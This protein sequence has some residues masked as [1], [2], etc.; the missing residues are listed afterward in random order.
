MIGEFPII[1]YTLPSSRTTQAFKYG[2]KIEKIWENVKH[3]LAHC[4][5]AL[6]SNP[7]KIELAVYSAVKED[8]HP[9]LAERILLEAKSLFGAAKSYSMGEG[10]PTETG[11]KLSG[12]DLQKAIAYL[13]NGQPWPKFTF[14][15]VE[16]FIVY[17]FKL[18]D[19]KTRVELPNQENSSH[20]MIWLGKRCSCS[21]DMW[22]PFPEAGSEF[23]NY[24]RGI[25]AYLPFKLEEKY[26]RR[27]KPNKKRSAY[28]FR[29]I[30]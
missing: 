24:L 20:I 1:L 27:G 2:N 4:T 7:D 15:P 22:F 18:I 28:I 6:V 10:L 11:W 8:K 5:T 14:G 21:S 12:D 29:K 26:L 16:L 3:F 17:D 23:W 25:D 19:P 9:E 13:Q 30:A